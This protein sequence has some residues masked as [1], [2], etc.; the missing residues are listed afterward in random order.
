MR[1]RELSCLPELPS[2]AGRDWALRGFIESRFA[3]HRQRMSQLNRRDALKFGL[4][5][6]ATLLVGCGG[7]DETGSHLLSRVPVPSPGP[8]PTP[9]PPPGTAAPGPA[10]APR[11][12]PTPAPTPTPPPPSAPGAWTVVLP[13]FTAGKSATYDLRSTL[14][15]GVSRGG[16]FGVAANGSPLPA[17]MTLAPVGILSVASTTVGQATGVIF[18]YSE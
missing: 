3:N 12:A 14:P 16:T 8:T 1:M 6:C 13:S 10:P 15:S 4:F 2:N 9:A 11:P 17:G 7:N 18:T 5:S